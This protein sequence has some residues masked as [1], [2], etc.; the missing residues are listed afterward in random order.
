MKLTFS[1]RIIYNNIKK[2]IKQV[3]YKYGCNY[4]LQFVEGLQTPSYEVKQ[5]LYDYIFQLDEK[6]K[7]NEIR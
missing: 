7:E 4:T 2:V 5:E 1:E 3:Y 6:E